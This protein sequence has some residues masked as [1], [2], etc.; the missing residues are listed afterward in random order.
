[1][2]R[3]SQEQPY[4]QRITGKDRVRGIRV[5]EGGEQPKDGDHRH[6]IGYLL[7]LSANG[8]PGSDDGRDAT[9]GSA[10]GDEG[11]QPLRKF[12]PFVDASGEK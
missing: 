11:A 10:D 8:R 7:F 5:D 6:C 1:M 2:D 4:L 9:D 3:S 12:E